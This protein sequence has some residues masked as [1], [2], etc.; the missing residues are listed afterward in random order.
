M[1]LESREYSSDGACR[2]NF[3]RHRDYPHTRKL[4]IQIALVARDGAVSGL[5]FT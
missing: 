4:G 1:D 5:Q 3:N 2:T